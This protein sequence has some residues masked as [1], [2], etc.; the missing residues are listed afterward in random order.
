MEL[1]LLAIIVTI[2]SSLTACSD[3]TISDIIDSDDADIDVTGTVGPE[4][5]PSAEG[6]LEAA[7]N[8]VFDDSVIYDIELNMPDQ[9]WLNI[10]SNPWAELWHTADFTWNG[11]VV[12]EVAVRAFGYSTLVPGKPPLKIDFNRNV[13]GQ[14]W[15]GLETLKLRNSYYDPSFMHDALAPWMLRTAGIPASRT[16]WAR[17]TVNGEIVGLY[18]VMEAIDDRFLVRNFGNDDGPLYSIDNIR[19][20]GLMPLTDALSYFQYNTGVEGDGSDL[21]QLT[22]IVASGTDE[23]LAA[24]LDVDAFFVESIVRSLTGSQDSFSADGN[25]FYLYNDP[26]VD[27]DPDDLHGTWRIIP[28]DY[29]FDFSAL[30]IWSALYVDAS[31][32]WATSGFAYDPYTGE[33]YVDVLMERQIAHGRDVDAAIAELIAGPLAYSDIV[34]KV[35]QYAALLAEDVALDPLGSQTAFEQ[36]VANDLLYL[37]VRFSNELGVDVADCAALETDATL[38]RD[39]SPQGTVGWGAVTV[40]GWYWG[41]GEVNCVGTDENCMGFDV[42]DKSYCTGLYTHAP[43]HVTI[44]IPDT[45]SSIRGAV[46]LQLFGEDCS[47]GASFSIVQNGVTLW[48][49]GVMYSYTAAEDIGDVSVEPGELKLITSD[50]GNFS[51]DMT[52]WLDLRAV[53]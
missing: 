32:P 5:V 10:A 15:R 24:V 1:K 45:A 12:T 26:S 27:A 48:E 31:M 51:C 53:P 33:P 37:H 41:D 19:G 35:R 16:G 4:Q 28:W 7:T 38:A 13:S 39:M 34:D 2:F 14:R 44:Q 30:G 22:T 49:S 52:S 50:R 20:H 47:T 40:D 43:S 36:A 17:V 25:N 42:R 23:E 11:E 3:G 21:E 9:S 6:Y 18:T 46:G 8:E 29:N